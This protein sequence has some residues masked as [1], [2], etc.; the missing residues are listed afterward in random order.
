ME[1]GGRAGSRACYARCARQTMLKPLISPISQALPVSPQPRW[2]D[3]DRETTKDYWEGDG[4]R[5][6]D[7]HTHCFTH[8]RMRAHIHTH[9]LSLSLS[10]AF[11]Q[12]EKHTHTFLYTHS[13]THRLK[14]LGVGRSHS[15]IHTKFM[16]W[17]FLSP[18]QSQFH[19]SALD[20]CIY[21]AQETAVLR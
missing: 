7:T 14:Y 4:K 17:T 19:P 2:G 8:A 5:E 9:T 6:S 16:I 11:S 1:R 10:L 3:G 21:P 20:K 18:P 12:A 13:R 15:I